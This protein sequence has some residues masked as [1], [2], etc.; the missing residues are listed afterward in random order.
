[1]RKYL[2]LLVAIGFMFVALP[3]AVAQELPKAAK[4]ENVKWYTV[5]YVKFVTSKAEDAQK[6]LTDY[7]IPADK[8]SG[9]DVINFDTKVGEWDHIAFFP[10][11]GGVAGLEWS[12][13]PN[14]EKWWSALAKLAG[15]AAKAQ[16]LMDQY[17]ES[18]AYSKSE[19]VMRQP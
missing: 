17:N 3:V 6:L 1:M 5:T 9:R 13:A 7:F 16:A 8:A 18:I 15:S 12:V 2:A 10:I 11:E 4:H 19:V 14:E